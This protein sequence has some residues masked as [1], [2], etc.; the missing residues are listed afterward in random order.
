MSH[1]CDFHVPCAMTHARCRL[2]QCNIPTTARLGSCPSGGAGGGGGGGPLSSS[3]TSPSASSLTLTCKFSFTFICWRL[4][5]AP[6]MASGLFGAGRACSSRVNSATADRTGGLVA[7]VHPVASSA[8][9]K[10][11]LLSR[12]QKVRAC[13][14]GQLTSLRWCSLIL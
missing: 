13:L 14:E 7:A 11:A 4:R 3:G 12:N 6:L 8:V 9:S 2:D 10:A 1:V 5:T